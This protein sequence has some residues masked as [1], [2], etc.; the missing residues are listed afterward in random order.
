MF[1]CKIGQHFVA[2]HLIEVPAPP[3]RHLW[4]DAREKRI[5]NFQVVGSIAHMPP[6]WPAQFQERF[7][8]ICS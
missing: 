3:D 6:Q 5:T 2:I 1:Q 8:Q 7:C 4:L